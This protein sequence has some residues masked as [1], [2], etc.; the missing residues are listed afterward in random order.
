[1]E[2]TLINAT[3]AQLARMKL[4]AEQNRNPALTSNFRK[5]LQTVEMELAARRDPT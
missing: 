3:D 1:M 2:R 4:L 5:L